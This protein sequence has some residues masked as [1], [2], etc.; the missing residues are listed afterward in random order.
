LTLLF[1]DHHLS[2][3]ASA[4]Y[5]SPHREAA[6]LTIDGVG[7]WATA[8][9]C[10]GIDKKITMLKEM[11]LPHSVG[12]LYSSFTYYLG[13]RV[14][15]GEYKLMG[16]APYGNPEAGQTK[17]FISLIKENVVSIRDD[18]SIW[19]NQEYFN[20]AWGLKMVN[21]RKWEGLFG[22]PAVKADGK[23][24]QKHCNLAY[25]IQKVTEEIV[26]KMAK[27]AQRLTGSKYLC[28]AGGVALNCVA[29]GKLLIESIYDDIYVQPAAGDA[30]A[31]LGAAQLAYHIYYENDRVE[32]GSMDAMQGTYLGPYFSDKE[33]VLTFRKYKAVYRRVE[34]FDDLCSEV[35]DLIS[36]GNVVGWFQ[37]R[38]EYG[39]RAL[40]N[41]S[42]L[43]D[44]RNI[45]MQRKLNL[46]IK[47][48]EGFRPFAPLGIDGKRKRLF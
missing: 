48:R 20:Y 5:P 3:A 25:A 22:F 41:R 46:K 8:S 40:G 43:A 33:A 16:L 32:T 27:E 12:L 28:M 1:S 34:N 14:N 44:A 2:H 31:A 4:F 24:E 11:R 26:I 47:Y 17:D 19:L 15:S 36:T 9:I 30:G 23:L 13:F 6:I 35:A 37:G 21:D 7:E 39:P 10:H 29:N 18:G 45:D 38:M 42:I